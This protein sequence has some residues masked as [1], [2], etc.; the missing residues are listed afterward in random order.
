MHKRLSIIVMVTMLLAGGLSQENYSTFKDQVSNYYYRIA[1]PDAENL[2]FL[3]T[4]AAYISFIEAHGDSTYYYPLKITWLVDGKSFYEVQPLPAV[5]DSVRKKIYAQAQALKNLWS[6]L[7][8]DFNKFVVREPLYD[9]PDSATLSTSNDT[10][11][12]YFS[13]EE[14]TR[15]ISSRQTFSKAGQLGRVIWNFGDRREV[16]YPSYKEVGGKWLC[17]GW[18]GQIYEKGE[19]ASGIRAKVI[20]GQQNDVLVPEQINLFVQRRDEKGEIQTFPRILFLKDF[21]FNQ[22]VQILNT[23]GDSTQTNAQQ[24]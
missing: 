8:P 10:I 4:S 22:N 23:A 18:D 20:Y 11:S 24:D 2:S 16:Y 7:F 12:I 19:V 21:K 1:A 5:S 14:K 6:Y 9:V 17:L 13:I 15:T 3:I